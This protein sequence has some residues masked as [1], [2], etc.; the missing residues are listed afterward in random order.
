MQR[1]R[2][3]GKEQKTIVHSYWSGFFT[4]T[5]ADAVG[6]ESSC[7]VPLPRACP[8]PHNSFTLQL[9]E[10]QNALQALSDIYLE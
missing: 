3:V 7:L 1:R 10:C 2:G 5:S 6:R 4:Y 8:Y 9:T